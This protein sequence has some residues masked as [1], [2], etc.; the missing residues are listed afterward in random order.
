MNKKLV[1]VISSVILVIIAIVVGIFIKKSSDASTKSIK[2]YYLSESNLSIVPEERKIKT[3][4][5]DE[6]LKEVLENILKGPSDK[7][8]KAV[9]GDNT[10]ILSTSFE[11]TSLTV[12]FSEEFLRNDKT[13][14]M[15]SVYA[16][17]KTLCQID[18]ISRVMITVEGEQ[19]EAA[20]STPIGFLSNADINLESDT[21]TPDS[22]EIILYFA[23]NDGKLEREIRTIKI[24]DTR[25]IESYIINELIKG[26]VNQDLHSTLS[27]ETELISVEKANNVC[28]VTFKNFIDANLSEPDSDESELAVYSIVNSLTELEDVNSVHF[29]FEGKT[30]EVV[31]Q[32]NFS[33]NFKKNKD[34]VEE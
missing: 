2:V 14:N 15:L 4:N 28:H 34:I 21:H 6:I 3:G 19:V 32:F 17:I 9:A 8:N 16:I 27:S 26:P 5:R 11:G 31:G 25:P 7:E 18:K 33:E 29:L 24:T 23:N 1:I 22:K 13:V 10:R 20:D 30:E 12:D